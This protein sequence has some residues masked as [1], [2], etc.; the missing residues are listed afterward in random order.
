MVF[1]LS[2]FLSVSVFVTKKTC[3]L[4]LIFIQIALHTDCTVSLETFMLELLG[5]I[6][7][8]WVYIHN[9]LAFHTGTLA[10]RKI[11]IFISV[12]EIQQKSV[13]QTLVSFILWNHFPVLIYIIWSNR[14]VI[15]FLCVSS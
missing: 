11:N 10:Y 9:P 12:K 13:S 2:P 4:T 14:G 5:N 1:W 15:V 6:N 7:V 8:K 3:S